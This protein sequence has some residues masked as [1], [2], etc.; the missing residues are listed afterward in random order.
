MVLFNVCTVVW[1]GPFV[2]PHK[3]AD[4][5]HYVNGLFLMPCGLTWNVKTS[6]QKV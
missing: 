1:I 2:F 3:G 6:L 4:I 5:S